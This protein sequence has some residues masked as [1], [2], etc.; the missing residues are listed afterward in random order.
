MIGAALHPSS[1][2]AMNR[3]PPFHALPLAC[4]LAIAIAGAVHA[5][6]AVANA[7]PRTGDA[8]TDARLL[9]INAYGSTYRDAFVD[10]L[11]RYH[12]AP[13]DLVQALLA[14]PGWTPG[15]VYVACALAV[16]AGRPCR[17]VADARAQDPSRGWED[18]AR[19]LGIEPGSPAFHALKRAVVA[20]YDRWAR[21]L[22]L[23][24][25]LAPDFPG[26]AREPLPA[27]GPPRERT[28]GPRKPASAANR[29]AG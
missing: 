14:R 9:D 10:E 11:V 12:R 29:P 25:E 15:D 16:Q 8:W 1:G 21:P 3:M 19:D 17:S 27:A 5:Q 13:R 20:S 7:G 18:V 23:D 22:V 24:A 28:P 26:R 4:L 6:G 2:D